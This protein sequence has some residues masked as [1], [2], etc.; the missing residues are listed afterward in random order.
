M[1]SVPRMALMVSSMLISF[2]MLAQTQVKEA[3]MEHPDFFTARLRSMDSPSST[4]RPVRKTHRQFC[5]FTAFRHRRECSSLSSPGFLIA[6][7]LLRP[8]IL[9]TAIATGLVPKEFAYTFDNIAKVMIHFSE[10]SGIN[11]STH[12]TC[13]TT[14][15]LVGFRMVLAHPERVDALIVQDAVAHNEGLGANW[16]KTKGSF[17]ANRKEN[18]EALRKN[19][20]SLETTRTRHVGDDANVDRYDPDLWTDEFAFLSPAKSGPN[21]K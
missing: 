5:C 21:S 8:T 17:W 10:A 6:I 3:T 7:T 11:P 19:L 1:I 16:K 14:A 18:E 15:A 12:C 20:L 13:R 2:Q 4:E 9:V